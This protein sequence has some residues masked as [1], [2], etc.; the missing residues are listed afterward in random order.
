M[1][2]LSLLLI[3]ALCVFPAL[4][5]KKSKEQ[6]ARGAMYPSRYDVIPHITHG[7]N[8]QSSLILMNVSPDPTFYRIKFYSPNGQ[9]AKFKS[10]SDG[11]V[12]ELYGTLAPGGSKR[13]KSIVDNSPNET[14]YWAEILDGAGK[15]QTTVVFGWRVPGNTPMDVSV[16]NIDGLSS[17]GI[18][19][20][21]DN[22]DGY[23]TALAFANSDGWDASEFKLEARNENGAVIFSRNMTIESRHQIAII[24]QDEFR[25][26][27]NQRG[28]I[29]LRPRDGDSFSLIYGA[30]LVLQFNPAGS[31]TYIPAYDEY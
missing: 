31:I 8:W 1:R 30:P 20:P 4:A 9:E 21:F 29:V 23:R 14:R 17:D 25:E 7:A 28:V 11:E 19:F 5:Q 12:H 16:P 10:Q 6:T 26:L 3:A 18:Y 22:T 27:A 13:V 2:Y 24:L 15:I